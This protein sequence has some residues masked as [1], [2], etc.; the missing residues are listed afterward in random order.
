MGEAL[1][2]STRTNTRSALGKT[3]SAFTSTDAENIAR[4]GLGE[5]ISSATKELQKF[6]LQLAEQTLP[7][8][9]IG[10]TKDVTLVVSEGAGLNIMEK[11]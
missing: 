2:D 9:E 4:A 8:I 6:Y 5:G 7:V 11:G 3:Q 1:G 10:S